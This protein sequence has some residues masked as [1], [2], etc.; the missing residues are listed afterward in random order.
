MGKPVMPD[1]GTRGAGPRAGGALLGDPPAVAGGRFSVEGTG[2]LPLAREVSDVC[3]RQDLPPR[4]L[5]AASPR[6][7]GSVACA[8]RPEGAKVA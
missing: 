5:R 8:G 2:F 1:V 4:G 3:P 7:P 6:R